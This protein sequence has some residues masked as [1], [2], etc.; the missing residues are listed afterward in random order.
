MCDFRTQE[1]VTE[2]SSDIS[3]IADSALGLVVTL[4]KYLN[5]LDVN[6]DWY[7]NIKT[8]P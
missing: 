6:I 1:I 7:E 3:D 4:N 2:I 5:I 8:L